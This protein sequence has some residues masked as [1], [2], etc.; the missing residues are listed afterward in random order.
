MQVWQPG[1]P[2]GRGCYLQEFV[3]GIPGS[4]VFVAA[5]GRAVPLGLSRQLVGECAFGASG[6][7]YCG[8]ILTSAPCAR[9]EELAAASMRLVD[10]VTEAF[11]L[12]GVGSIDFIASGGVPYPVEVNPRWSA[13]MELV[14]RACG[15]SMFGVHAEACARGILPQFDVRHA[16]AEIAWGKAVL[17]A[18]EDAVVGDARAWLDDPNVRDV[19]HPG[20]H[21]RAGSPICTVFGEGRDA[22]ACRDA[23]VQRA[24]RVYAEIESWSGAG[25]SG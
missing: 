4:V 20:E 25:V 24:E 5:R 1:A 2:V 19:P 17:F 9:E 6:F 10:A 11:D 13:S 16:R 15:L 12:V 18:R 3:D 8:S 23:L 21:I 14:E 7:R 22:D